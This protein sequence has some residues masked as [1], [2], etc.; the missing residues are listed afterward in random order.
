M[1]DRTALVVINM[2]AFF[3]EV[4]EYA[5]GIV[6]NITVLADALRR[7]GGMV[8]WV[9]PGAN[10][11]SVA[12][13]EFLGNAIAERYQMSGGAGTPRDRLWHELEAAEA[14]VVVEKSTKSAFFPVAARFRM[15]SMRV[16]STPCSSR[17]PSPTSAAN[18]PCVTRARSATA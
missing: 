12:R 10:Q 9:V 6:P 17:A 11:P 3:V 5:R 7:R 4:N 2:V 13:R 14:D 8:A 1:P 16:G 15:C 18:P